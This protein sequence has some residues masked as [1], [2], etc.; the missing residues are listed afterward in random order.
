MAFSE[1]GIEVITYCGPKDINCVLPESVLKIYVDI[2]YKSE[3]FCNISV[4]RTN[5]DCLISRFKITCPQDNNFV[6]NGMSYLFRSMFVSI[7]ASS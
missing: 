7:L 5:L 1:C 6:I 2:S 3:L 4:T